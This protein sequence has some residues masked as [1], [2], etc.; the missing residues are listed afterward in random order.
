VD[1][2]STTL[3]FK[4]TIKKLRIFP[5]FAQIGSSENANSPFISEI[6][7]RGVLEDLIRSQ[8]S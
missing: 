2:R 8:I 1:I 3:D 7:N 5:G 4:S 6:E